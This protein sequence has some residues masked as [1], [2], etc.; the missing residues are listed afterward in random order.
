[1][2]RSTIS[3]A[4][5]ILLAVHLASNSDISNL[6]TLI[7][8]NRKALRTEIV[9]RI[10]LSHLPECVDPSEYVPLVQELIDGETRDIEELPVDASILSEITENEASKRVKRLHLL[11]VTWPN[12]PA[13]GPDDLLARFLIHRSMRIDQ[14][15]GLIDQI[16]K[17]ISPFIPGSNELRA[18]M[19][20]TVLPL[21]RLSYEYHPNEHIMTTLGTF[22]RM[23]DEEGLALLLSGT[24]KSNSAS[25]GRDASKNNVGRDLRGLVGPWMY[26]DTRSKRRKLRKE[27]NLNGQ[28]TLAQEET[29]DSKGK[30]AGWEEVFKWVTSQARTSWKTAVQLIEQWDGPGDV[31]LGGYEDGTE[32]LDDYDQQ[33]LEQR[34]ARSALASAYLIPDISLEALLGINSILTRLIL[35][36]DIEKLPT[37]EA[38]GALLTPVM[39]LGNVL[40]TKNGIFL[41]NSYMEEDNVLT[42][43]SEES[44]RL[45]HALL[46]SAYLFTK[47]G[48]GITIK[49]AA[50][51]TLLQQEFE[52]R[53]EFKRLL[54]VH[55][56]RGPKGDD[57]YWARTRNEILWLRNWGA[58]DLPGNVAVNGRGIFGRLSKEEIEVSLLKTLLSNNRIMLAQSVYQNSPEKPLSS[59][60]LNDT[61]ITAAMEAYDNATNGNMTR[62]GVKRCHDILNAFRDKLEESTRKQIEALIKVTNEISEYRLVIKKEPFKPVVL[63]VHSDPVSILGMIL[64]QNDGAYTRVNDFMIMAKQMVEAGL[65]KKDQS[66]TQK[67]VISMCI[68]AALADD[69]YETAYSYVM[70]RLSN[71]AGPS[72]TTNKSHSRSS[73]GLTAEILPVVLDDW[74]WKAALQAGKYRRNQNTVKPTHFGNSSGNIEIRHLQQRMDCLAL[75]LR[76]APSSALQEILN[77]YRRC[78]EELETKMREE[79][80][81]EAAWDDQGDNQ[82]MP[83]GFAASAPKRKQDSGHGTAEEAPMSLFDLA[84]AS[85]ARAQSGLAALSVLQGNKQSEPEKQRPL[86]QVSAD[87]S[88]DSGAQRE[89][90]RDQIR[91]V[92]AGTLASGLGWVLGAP[93]PRADN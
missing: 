3:P 71:V 36:L 1:M 64:D 65:I 39:H 47:E 75:A 41:R 92:A 40:S 81:E 35:L 79:E 91:N 72:R 15:T 20:T 5:A 86:S 68:D 12:S 43:P 84:R 42:W 59:K 66:T 80:E 46:V 4:K 82:I 24:G 34:Y 78:E 21:L 26:G 28:I 60:T 83:G 62:G 54:L 17:L 76:F 8:Q 14:Y 55:N 93:A 53:E 85:T 67:R 10:L 73:S 27:S 44:L 11:P 38:A 37:L 45:L 22:E 87:G 6:R 90:K 58:E 31:D 23:S 25:D 70:T 63:R 74:S 18:W 57:R 19:I 7:S 56:S 30:Y 51:L 50:E 33:Y 16:P 13:D 29:P 9:L 88:L 32:I 77:A 52:Q 69:D 48:T 49:R 2:A 89:R 61:L